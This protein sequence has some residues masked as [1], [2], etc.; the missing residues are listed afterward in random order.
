MMLSYITSFFNYFTQKPEEDDVDPE[1]FLA[2]ELMELEANNKEEGYDSYVPEAPTIPNDAICF[3]RTGVIDYMGENY[4][5]IDGFLYVDLMTCSIPVSLNDKVLYLSYNDANGSVKVV[6]LLQNLGVSWGSEDQMNEDKF[7]IIEHVIIGEVDCRQERFV[8]IK[9]S[10]L[11]FSLDNVKGTFVPI[12]GDWLEMK[13][14]VQYDEN[15]P[16]D[17][18]TSQVLQVDSY[19]PLRTKIK[20]VKVSYWS[21]ETGTCDKN[22]YFTKQ[23]I[24]GAIVPQVGSKVLV[25][26]IESNQATC[27]WRA[28]KVVTLGDLPTKEAIVQIE[29]NQTDVGQIS[30]NTE[31]ELNIDFTYPIAFHNVDLHKSEKITVT[32]KN[33]SNQTYTMNKWLVLSKKRDSQVNIK[34][35]LAHPVK[36]YPN[37]SYNFIIACHPKF[38]GSS[39]EC[40]IIMFKGFQL[41]RFIEINVVDDNVSLNEW[42]GEMKSNKEK[43]EL[44]RKVLRNNDNTV[45]GIKPVRPPNFVQV[46][47]G[48]FP[49]PEKVWAAVLGNSEQTM[50]SLEYD[51]IIERIETH[52]PCLTQELKINNYTDRWHTLLYM[53]EIQADISMRAYDTPRAFLIRCQDYLALEISGLSERRPSL[54][55]GDSVIAKDIWDDKSTKYEGCIHQI[56]GDL[57]LMK[58][59]PRFHETYSGGDVS[60]EFHFS[61]SVYR[62]A[63]QAINLAL[64]NL[65][66]EM[67]FPSRI[68]Q[69]APQLP[70]KHLE[71]IKW[72]DEKLNDGQKAAVQNI[73]SG[74][75]RPLP[76][77]IFGPP[78]TGKTVTVIET[79][80]QILTQL[81]DS[82]ILVAT[83]SN[84]AANLITERLIQNRKAFSSSMIRLIANY[85]LDSDNIPEA[86]KPFCATLDIATENTS[87]SKY[88]VK[89]G[90]NLHC[91][92]S[93][94]G[95]HR[96]TI[97][98]CYCI[99]NLAL[100]GLPRGHFTHVIVDEA[101]QATEPEIMIPLT[102]IEKETGQVILAGDPMQLG[103]VVMSKYCKAFE[104]DESYMCR[105]LDTFPY[106]RDYDGFANGFNNKLITKLNDNYRSLEEVLRLPSE[107][108]YDGSLVPRINRDQTWIHN[109]INV[110]SD[111]YDECD[112]KTGGIF[113]CGIRGTN[114]RAEDSPSWYNPQEASMVALATCKLYKKGVSPDDIGIITPYIA[115]IK[116]LR[117]IFDA[118]GLFRPKI[119]TVEEFQGQ[120]RPIILIS[121]VR[122]TES[123]LNVDERHKLGFVKNP[124]R[125]NVALTR[126]QVAVILFCNPHLLCT[127]ALWGKVI[128]NAVKEN[129]YRG[130]DLPNIYNDFGNKNVT[131]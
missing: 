15:K 116:H 124:K 58:F 81:P 51:K 5:L 7:K 55:K 70:S 78:G 28:I 22:I 86:I 35:F 71:S 10:D 16:S 110:I 40:F 91:Q 54:V 75:G 26:A 25:E 114:A 42:N 93:F 34:P 62:R 61:R 66:P 44:M 76:Y 72:F 122:S 33:N 120:E 103:P 21:G 64:T 60:L 4:A 90:I 77:I 129:K 68:T 104:M 128:D 100:M 39:K 117:L 23:S 30:L 87:Q 52:L 98:T 125:L 41:K 53:E 27:T 17:I 83:P 8:C 6:R 115:Q 37:Q 36:L 85:M 112:D 94:I 118:M 130:C 126:A 92:K 108:F 56:K 45:P 32:V 123:L 29:P 13:C 74:E 50:Y 107:L 12:K 73:L 127:D 2:G 99:G 1:E 109:F 121:T 3:Q 59:N 11:K 18:S 97:G 67:L 113:V 47:L 79:I 84:S 89:D 131:E 24:Q 57:I 65:G 31:K 9:D 88:T 63:H 38:L 102:F 96:V 82:R 46:R 119:G 101:G 69:R 20:N 105:I 80:L 43:I 49:I 48:N 19:K 95:R 106:Q 14:T 111:S